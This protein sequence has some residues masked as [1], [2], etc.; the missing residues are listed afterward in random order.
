MLDVART[1]FRSGEEVDFQPTD[2]TKLPFSDGAFDAV[3]CQFGV[4]FF[5]QKDTSYREVPSPTKVFECRISC[6]SRA[7]SRKPW[8][9]IWIRVMPGKRKLSN[10]VWV[11]KHG[12]V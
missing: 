3:V 12:W 8:G 11:W 2:A 6:G 10:S 9:R 1:K 4:M 7:N 5:P